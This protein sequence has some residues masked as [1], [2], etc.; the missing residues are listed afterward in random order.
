MFCII[1]FVV[2][3]FYLALSCYLILSLK[4]D[5]IFMKLAIS[6]SGTMSLYM[7]IEN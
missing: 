7:M 1:C 4:E 5:H 3:H 2:N 6:D